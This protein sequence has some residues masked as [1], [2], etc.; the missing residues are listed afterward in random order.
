M[1]LKKVLSSILVLCLLLALAPF[2]AGEV[3]VEDT[4]TTTGIDVVVVLDMTN[5]MKENPGND[6]FNYRVDAT[7][8]L[9]GML[10]MDGS[11]V[12]VVPFADA[13]GKPVAITDFTDV[14]SS[15]KRK[16][17]IDKIY[18]NYPDKIRPNTNIGAALMKANQMLLTRADQSNRSMIVLMTDGQNA[19]NPKEKVLV[20][21]S[22][23]WENGQIVE[24]K[25]GED[26]DTEK[27]D[28]VTNEAFLCAKAN[29][30]PV[31]T[32]ALGTDPTTVKTSK[33]ISLTDISLGTGALECQK[34]NKEEAQKLPT[35]FAKVLANQIGSS[36]EY[37]AEPEK[38]KGEKDTYEVK[39]PVPNSKV[40]E[41]NIILPVKAGV[42]KGSFSGIVPDSF[43]LR[44]STG[45]R[46][47]ISNEITMLSGFTNSHFAMIK[48]RE[49]NNPGMWTLRFKSEQDP[50]NA[51]FNILYKYNIKFGV[52]IQNASGSPDI[53]KTDK[54]NVVARFVE[55]NGNPAEDSELYK[56]HKGEDGYA[57]WMTIRSAWTLCRTNSEGSA[58]GDPLKKGN[59]TANTVQ[60]QF[61]TKIDLSEG[62]KLPSGHYLLV[63]TAAGA[64]M[65]RTVEIPLDLKNHEP[66]ANEYSETIEVNS[67]EAGKEDTWKVDTTSGKL[68]KKATEIVADADNDPVQFDLRPADS[69]AQ[70]VAVM[71]LDQATGEISFKTVQ[72]GDKIKPG[73]ARYDLHYN[74]Q[75]GGTGKVAVTLVVHSEVD[76][77]LEAYDLE[78]KITGDN[79]PGGDDYLKNTPMTITARLKDKASSTYASGDILAPLKRHIDIADQISGVS[80]VTNGE[81]VLN[82][83]ALEFSIP[84]T[85]NQAAEWAVN[86]VVDPYEPYTTIIRIPNDNTP[87]PAA[88]DRVTVNCNGNGV[89]GFIGENTPEDDSSRIVAISGLFTDADGDLLSYGEP[90]FVDPATGAEISSNI[91]RAEK[92]GEGE[93][94][95]YTVYVSGEDTSLF[96]F[97]MGSEMRLTA[98][99]GD[100]KTADYVRTITIV[101]LHNK[102]ITYIIMALIA[103]AILVI[104]Y[105]IVHQIRKP[106]FPKLNITTREEPS[107]YESGSETLS[108]VKTYT[109]INAL[110]V[111]G[112]MAD[113]HGISLDLLQNIIIKPVRSRTAV[114][115]LCKKAVPGHEVMLEDVRMKPK[116]E[117]AWKIG[118]ELT[119]RSEN[120]DGLVALKLEECPDGNE[121][122]EDFQND[123]W[124]DVDENVTNNGGK[125]YS[126][127]AQKKTLPVEEEQNFGSTDDFDF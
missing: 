79:T 101:D 72:S 73:T 102:M 42:G 120:G 45:A 84:S 96:R 94:A 58:I 57:D 51:S 34:V 116:K 89:P 124:A 71:T 29:N 6:P 31:Y 125:K 22:L 13:P 103:I 28:I 16:D 119:V 85:G 43:E 77:M 10:D 81:L 1:N 59:L 105:L 83:D 70:S 98:T 49:P 64:G 33:G 50:K 126:R 5:S 67:T 78:V 21:P 32:I 40:L 47:N 61:E 53:Y 23:R 87:V 12:A 82:G 115:V 15:Q 48:I 55:E 68:K 65:N 66:V 9:I 92:A 30:I 26:Y 127:K 27:A 2:A 19:I 91:I 75:D 17:L 46:K 54:L 123:E 44:D 95:V 99:D 69:N 108:P 36:V 110:G 86:L 14:S 18:K 104:L 107:L 41:T 4:S 20:K 76:A 122:Y 38:V 112:D 56:D 118:Q 52:D 60:N 93:D 80:V 25:N 97:S 8:M 88:D 114:G 11:R 37:T 74:D 39:I 7:A 63:V 109:N 3:M 100:G 90:R 113:K 121:V 111:D 24:K 35:F 117:Y 62:D 106:V